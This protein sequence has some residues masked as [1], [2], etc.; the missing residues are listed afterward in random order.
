MRDGVRLLWKHRANLWPA[1]RVILMIAKARLARLGIPVAVVLALSGAIGCGGGAGSAPTLQDMEA[2]Q[3]E[4]SS[5]DRVASLLEIDPA[6]ILIDCKSAEEKLRDAVGE[7]P[8]PPYKGDE[9]KTIFSGYV[10]VIA[11]YCQVL[12]DFDFG[13]AAVLGARVDALNDRVDAWWDDARAEFPG[14]EAPG[15]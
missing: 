13:Q 10:N 1:K 2:W 3:Q 15:Y 6:D 7:I 5:N 4:V 11:G 8:A 12:D 9:W 14:L